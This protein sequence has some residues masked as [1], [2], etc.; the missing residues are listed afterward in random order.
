[1]YIQME[2][3]MYPLIYFQVFLQLTRDDLEPVEDRPCTVSESRDSLQ[4][5]ANGSMYFGEKASKCF[6]FN[7]PPYCSPA[8]TG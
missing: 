7:Y 3:E 4:D 5:D 2:L 1:M 6:F 8:I